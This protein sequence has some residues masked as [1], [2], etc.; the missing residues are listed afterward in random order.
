ARQLQPVEPRFGEVRARKLDAGRGRALEIGSRQHGTAEVRAFEPRVREIGVFKERKAQIGS[1]EVGPTE[2]GSRRS[3]PV[4]L[5][6]AARSFS[7]A[8]R[9]RSASS[10]SRRGAGGK[11][12]ARLL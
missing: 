9:T 2:S 8:C 11:F 3:R 6:P 10:L 5:T 1:R 4:R 12:W 7:T